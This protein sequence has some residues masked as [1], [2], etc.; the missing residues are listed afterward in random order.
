MNSA[1]RLPSADILS[2][3]V[4]LEVE[5]E[6][7]QSSTFNDDSTDTSSDELSDHDDLEGDV[8][9]TMQD[10]FGDSDSEDEEQ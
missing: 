5:E 3:D 7:V 9:V 2:A 8:A 4:E 10:I 1:S 6:E